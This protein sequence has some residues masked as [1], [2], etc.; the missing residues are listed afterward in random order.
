MKPIAPLRSKF[1]MFAKLVSTAIKN[2]R[3]TAKLLNLLPSVVHQGVVSTAIKNPRWT[4]ESLNELP[5]VVQGVQFSRETDFSTPIEVEDD[6]LEAANPLLSYFNSHREGLGIWKWRHYFDIYQR[7]F[8]KFVGREVHVLEVGILSGGSL[9]MWKEYFG[10]GCRVYGV[11]IEK[12]CMAY[13][14]EKVEVFIGDQADRS[15]W[16]RVRQTVPKIDILIDDGGHHHEQQRITLEE[17]LPHLRPGG[18]YFCEDIHRVPNHFA[19]YLQGLASSLHSYEP[20]EMPSGVSDV[21]SISSN[22]QQAISAIHLYPFVAV[23]EKR[24]RNVRQFISLKQG[25]Q[26]QLL[27][28]SNVCEP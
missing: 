20:S 21:A 15:F 8:S 18:V 28:H 17:M 6:S 4:V 3:R 16:A 26:W 13:K 11:D 9:V 12:A 25:T 7:Y 22:F 2:P 10:S 1:S 14:Q 5:S 24:E 27:S 23:I 19:S